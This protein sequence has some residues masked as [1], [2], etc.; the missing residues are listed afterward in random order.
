M[1]EGVEGTTN[2]V[3]HELVNEA[4]KRGG[5]KR[6]EKDPGDKDLSDVAEGETAKLKVSSDS[7]AGL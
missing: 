1:G 6:T 4:G 7:K 2:W 3:L 5:V